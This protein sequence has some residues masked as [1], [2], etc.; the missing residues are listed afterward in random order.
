MIDFILDS[1]C[2]IVKGLKSVTAV[3]GT[4]E[5]STTTPAPADEVGMDVEEPTQPAAIRADPA[6][7]PSPTTVSADQSYEEAFEVGGASEVQRA[8]VSKDESGSIPG[9]KGRA[10]TE[11]REPEE[12]AVTI[13][14]LQ[15]K[16]RTKPKARGELL[17][18][19][20]QSFRGG[21]LRVDSNLRAA[22]FRSL[23][24]LVSV[25]ESHRS[26]YR[27]HVR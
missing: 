4:G 24:Y 10:A 17:L 13:N 22:M 11:E 19:L 27:R 9:E 23:R 26:A 15:Q 21:M 5:V 25:V 18:D 6:P 7:T 14:E 16:V 8:G 20:I 1:H 3:T 12:A 2:L